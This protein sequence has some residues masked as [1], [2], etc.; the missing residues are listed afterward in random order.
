[1]PI[2]EAGPWASLSRYEPLLWGLVV[3]SMVADTALTYYGIERGFVE[4]NPVA[5]VALERFGYVALG[6]L[7]LLA[8]GVG[9]AGRTLL[10]AEYTAIVPLG[11][12]IPWI[13]ASLV[14]ATLIAG[15]S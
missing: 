1:M 9:L 2:H 11:L 14:N 4:G 8:L 10:P 15:L 7:K 5:R 13:V 6:A 3:V 12:A